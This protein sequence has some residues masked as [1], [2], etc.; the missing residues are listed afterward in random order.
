M[1]ML[2][3]KQSSDLKVGDQEGWRSLTENRHGRVDL[4]L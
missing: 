1:Q 4:R 2:W 3:R